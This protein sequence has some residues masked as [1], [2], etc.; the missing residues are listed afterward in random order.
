[1]TLDMKRYKPM[2]APLDDPMKNPD[3]FKKLRYPLDVS[4][5]LDGWRMIPRSLPI[6]EVDADFNEYETGKYKEAALT[7]ELNEFPSIQVQ[8]LYRGFTDL[9]GEITAGSPTAPGVYNR[10]QSHVSSCNKPH[11]DLQFHVFDCADPELAE[12]PFEYRLEHARALIMQYRKQNPILEL[13]QVYLVEHERVHNYDELIAVEA[14][15]LALGYEGLMMRDPYG[16]YKSHARC[17]FNEGW[18]YK[19]K[20]FTD[21]EGRILGFEQ[22]EKN[23]NE[24]ETDER[25]YAKRS[26]AKA[27]KVLANTIG[28]IIV[29]FYGVA[30]KV[31]PGTLT[32]SEREYMFRNQ[33]E[34]LGQFLKFRYFSYGIKELPRYAR[35]IGM[36]SIIDMGQK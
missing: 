32:H 13:S 26:D 7:R 11:E 34:F 17:T 5:K 27:G 18:I 16:P 22:G 21:D 35:A 25:G 31:A 4:P 19:L 6:I 10:T 30:I 23:E 1:M 8:Q 28:K 29:D 12:H 2:L 36:R 9:D 14:R 3:F 20:R 24:L 33:E 15:V